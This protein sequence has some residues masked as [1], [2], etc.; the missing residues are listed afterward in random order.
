MAKRSARRAKSRR[1]T[2]AIC[3][4]RNGYL[5]TSGGQPLNVSAKSTEVWGDLTIARES[6][7]RGTASPAS[8]QQGPVLKRRSTALVPNQ[9]RA[10]CDFLFTSCLSAPLLRL[11]HLGCPDVWQGEQGRHGRRGPGDRSHAGAGSGPATAHGKPGT[12]E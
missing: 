6:A 11:N 2:K 10:R 1:T 3:L 8:C 4:E 12:R 5:L 9:N 7:A